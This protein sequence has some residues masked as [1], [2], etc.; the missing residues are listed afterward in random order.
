[1]TATQTS[2]RTR[3][4]A[5]QAVRWTVD[6]GRSSVGFAVRTFWGAEHR[7]RPLRALRRRLRGR[8]G[9]H[10]DSDGQCSR[11]G[12]LPVHRS[13][14]HAAASLA[15]PSRLWVCV[16]APDCYGVEECGV[17]ALVLVGVGLG[18]VSDR[19]IKDVGGT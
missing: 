19:A 2:T 12:G 9:R 3:D 10:A 4:T 15:G 5:A 6:P 1:M 8:A 16:Y 18:K 13:V 11:Q 14:H 7:S 17:V